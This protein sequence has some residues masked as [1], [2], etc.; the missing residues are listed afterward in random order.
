MLN[1]IPDYTVVSAVICD[2]IRVEV[3]S[4]LFFIGVYSA[5]ISVEAVPVTFGVC[6]YLE[7]SLPKGN[8]SVQVFFVLDDTALADMTVEIDVVE[9]GVHG[10]ASPRFAVPVSASCCLRI[11]VSINGGV[12][13]EVQRRNIT[14][15]QRAPTDS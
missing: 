1:S 6:A 3:N 5:G 7:I 15:A 4:K 14:L 2:E 12:R 10:I 9:A 8:T 11:E 13:R